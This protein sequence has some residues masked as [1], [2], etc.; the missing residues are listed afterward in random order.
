MGSIN[1]L[2]VKYKSD[3][4][5]NAFIEFETQIYQ[6]S[7]DVR[8][9]EK[10]NK[11]EILSFIEYAKHIWGVSQDE[12]EQQIPSSADNGDIKLHSDEYIRWLEENLNRLIK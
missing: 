8:V 6:E 9:F 11:R 10:F 5:K 3:T 2:H 12:L 1:L 7:F 4:G